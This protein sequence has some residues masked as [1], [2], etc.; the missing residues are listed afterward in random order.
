MFNKL[1]LTISYK[2]KAHT[3]TLATSLINLANVKD[4]KAFASET[5]SFLELEAAAISEELGRAD[6]L[7]PKGNQLTSAMAAT[8]RR[9]ARG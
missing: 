3:H 5:Q 2:N 9:M 6:E 7:G 8:E 1:K 4:V